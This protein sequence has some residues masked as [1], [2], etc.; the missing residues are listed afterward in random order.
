[1]IYSIIKNM[2]KP[3][4]SII[5]PVY[6][7]KPHRLTE[8]IESVLRQTYTN[9]ELIIINDASTNDIE[10]TILQFVEKDSRIRY[11]KNIESSKG[12]YTNILNQ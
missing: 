1:M 8:S 11:I 6:N 7:S 4:V 5:L 2:K 9:F 10:K 3:L 12:I